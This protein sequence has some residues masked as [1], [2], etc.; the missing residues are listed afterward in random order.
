MVVSVLDLNIKP[1]LFLTQ[2]VDDGLGDIGHLVDIANPVVLEKNLPKFDSSG[3]AVKYKPI[4]AVICSDPTPKRLR[5]II[6]SLKENGMVNDDGISFD[7]NKD[8]ELEQ[9]IQELREKNPHFY[10]YGDRL[11]RDSVSFLTD[12]TPSNITA[13]KVYAAFLVSYVERERLSELLTALYFNQRVFSTKI[14][15]HGKRIDTPHV[16]L[17]EY[18]QVLGFYPWCCGVFLK[19]PVAASLEAKAH[20]LMGMHNRTLLQ[21][22]LQVDDKDISYEKAFHFLQ[23]K[24]FIPAY[25]HHKQTSLACLLT[26]AC[27]DPAKTYEDVVFYGLRGIEELQKNPEALSLL[28]KHGYNKIT[29]YSSQT[30]P[31]E[32]NIPGAEGERKL[33]IYQGYELDNPDYYRLF[34]MAQSFGGCAGDKSLELVLSNHLI[35]FYEE[36]RDIKLVAEPLAELAFS[37]FGEQSTL[38]EYIHCF[39]DMRKL[40]MEKIVENC[41]K[42]IALINTDFLKQ[43]GALIETCHKQYN[44][45]DKLAAIFEQSL[46]VQ[47]FYQKNIKQLASYLKEENYPDALKLLSHPLVTVTALRY[48]RRCCLKISELAH[49]TVFLSALIRYKTKDLSDTLHRSKEEIAEDVRLRHE[50]QEFNFIES[51]RFRELQQLK[52]LSDAQMQEIITQSLNQETRVGMDK[53]PS[54]L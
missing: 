20:A 1:I 8:E 29:V 50:P 53:A 36:A 43:W 5:F 51:S 22:L 23:K 40:P 14:K 6:Q 12:L 54:F 41:I 37:C 2:V 39:S 52:G 34:Q 32:F 27:S 10:L 42:M 25:F 38:P 45:Y 3:C 4:Y 9:Y 31:H 30:P 19:E 11:S 47:D 24:L 26:L 46:F 13:L 7:L 44:T 35:P 33:S 21:D 28:K 15:E 48:M 18:S 17:H 49:V 16:N